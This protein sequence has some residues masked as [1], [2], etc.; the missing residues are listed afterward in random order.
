MDAADLVWNR[1]AMEAGGSDPRPGDVALASALSVHS[2]AMSAGLLEGVERATTQQLDA[3]DAGYRWLGLT[4]VADVVQ[5]VRREIDAGALDDDERAV[6][7]ELRADH[8]Y[9]H[10]DEMI[11]E[12]F[13]GRWVEDPE[14]FAPLAPSEQLDS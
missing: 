3:A 5:M 1:A 12:A 10:V 14:A 13:E 6:A 11:V 9:E 8:E 7:L 2:L 4:A